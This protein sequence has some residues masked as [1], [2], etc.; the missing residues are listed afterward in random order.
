MA[1]ANARLYQQAE[2]ARQRAERT[3]DRTA[4][5]QAVTAALSES[6][7][8]IQVAEVIAQQTSAVVNAASVL[9]A[10]VTPQKDELEIIHY[11]G[12]GVDPAPEWQRF[13]LSTAT[14]LSDAVRTGQ[15]IWEETLEERIARYPHLAETYIKAKYPAWISLPLMLEGQA[16]GG[17]SVTFAQLPQLEP[18]DR[19]F[20]LALAQQCAQA[21][22]RAQLYEAEQQAR[23]QAEAA[24]RTK[25]EFL[26]MLSHELRTPMN[27]ILGWS[28]LLQRGNLDANRTKIALETIERNAKLQVQLI[29]DLLDV[30]RILQ[31]KLSLNPCPVSLAS[32]IDAAISTVRLAADAKTIQI[33]T[34]I[35]A[36]VGHVLGDAARLQQVIWNLLS[37]AVKFTPEQGQIEIQLTTVGAQA[38]IQVKDTGKG[39]SAEFLPFV[40]DTFRQADSSITRT[41]GGLGLGLAIAHHIVELH[42]GTIHVESAGEGQGATFT[43]KF[44]LLS[45]ST[46]LVQEAT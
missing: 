20:M 39:I 34:Q 36:N 16:V 31:G 1:I 6:L 32:V 21:I 11:L 35:A 42:G 44:P 12:D 46:A 26:A 8:P 29:E 22:V 45:T 10:L 15:P 19:A 18:D 30:S 2:Q 3:A 24:N 27:P 37:N 14:P 4:R 17:M 41:F 43:V 7:T 13:P 25:D 28:R 33:Q 5:L 23:S 9:V 38:Q 40:F